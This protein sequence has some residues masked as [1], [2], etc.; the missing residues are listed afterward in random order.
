MISSLIHVLFRIVL[1]NL[2]II[3]DFPGIFLLLVSSPMLLWFENS[4]CMTFL[5]KFVVFYGIQHGLSCWMSRVILRRMCIM[6]WLN[7]VVHRWQIELIDG[8]VTLNV[9]LLLFCLVDPSVFDRMLRSPSI[10]VD[11]SI[12]PCCSIS[13]CLT[14]FDDV[15]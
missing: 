7:E 5:F 1:F 9:F 13:F 11:P 10:V 8:T 6:L 14:Y 4:H 12:C 3:W 2:H 15:V